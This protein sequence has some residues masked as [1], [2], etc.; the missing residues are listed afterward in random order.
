MLQ[1]KLLALSIGSIALVMI[2]MCNALMLH[3]QSGKNRTQSGKNDST[4][5]ILL[6]PKL[7]PLET[8]TGDSLSDDN[9]S[10]VEII[11]RTGGN[12]YPFTPEQDTAY[13]R[14]LRLH[15]PTNTLAQHHA[16]LFSGI[17][18][19]MHLRSQKTPWDIARQNLEIP[20]DYYKPSSQDRA[21]YAYNIAKSQE[22]PTGLGRTPGTGLQIPL[23]DIYAFFG[24]TEDVS[25][26]INYVVEFPMNVEVVVYSP[27]ARVIAVI[28]K[29]KQN[30][31]NYRVTWNGRDEKG[32]KMPSG[33]YVAEVRLGNEQFVRKRIQIP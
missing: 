15:T 24:L 25:P 33:D 3:A 10:K 8:I 32:R 5:T 28:I 29:G 6:R 23:S 13:Y 7:T 31:G 16:R 21:L 22:I 27:Q 1:S 19:E 30:P 18:S 11:E 17:W 9:S 2:M 26:V 14:A 12:Q 4:K 20:A